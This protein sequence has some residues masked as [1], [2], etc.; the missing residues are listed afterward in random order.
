[1]VQSAKIKKMLQKEKIGYFKI[2][3]SFRVALIIVT[4]YEL[5]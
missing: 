2:A 4:F 5:I 3:I 1:M